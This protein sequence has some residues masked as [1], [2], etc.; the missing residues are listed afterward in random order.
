MN[1]LG[2]A[3]GTFDLERVICPNI[4]TF[5]SVLIRLDNRSLVR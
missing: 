1:V 5:T 4:E 3:G 2:I